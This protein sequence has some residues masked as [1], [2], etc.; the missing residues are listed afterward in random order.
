MKS[1][2][3]KQ[4]KSNICK[5]VFKK[6]NTSFY[7]YHVLF[8]YALY[9][10]VELVFMLINLEAVP[11]DFKIFHMKCRLCCMVAE[12]FSGVNLPTLPMCVQ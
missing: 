12:E 1:N 2:P 11:R 10:T 3:T 4:K 9:Y 6:I 7:F 8:N 5:L